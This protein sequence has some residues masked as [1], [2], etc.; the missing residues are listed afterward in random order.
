MA[1]QEAV[2]SKVDVRVGLELGGKDPAYIRPDVD[3]E[4]AAEE[5]VDGA[6]F[7]SGQSCCSLERV[8]VHESIH[9]AFVTAVQGVLRSYRLG[10]PFD[11]KTQIGPVISK[12]A[13]EAIQAHVK[14]AIEKGAVDSSPSNASFQSPPEAG[15]YVA[16][17][18]LTNVTHDMKVMRE[19]TFGPIIPVM[20][21]KDDR[22]AV[23]LMND[24][25]FGLTA[26]I[27][28]KDVDQGHKLADEVEAGTCFIN[29]CDYPSPVSVEM[30]DVF[31][32]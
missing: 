6:I 2:S 27:W 15:N 8:Y 20:K 10:D 32:G 24:S 26:S 28:T 25:D 13:V 12:Q 14:D 21:V 18:L 31:F 30:H 19:E 3:V 4:W 22:E 17:T 29:R 11:E 9:D 7:N 23:R 5:I 1:A 16:P